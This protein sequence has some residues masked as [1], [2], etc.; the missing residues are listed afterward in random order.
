MSETHLKKEFKES[1]LSRNRN[2]IEKKFEILRNQTGI[3]K[4]DREYVEGDMEDDGKKWTIK[5]W[6]KQ[7]V[8]KYDTLKQSMK[9]PFKCPGC[10][11]HFH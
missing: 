3:L 9:L 7:T 5:G 1:D 8:T 4:Q 10:K 2:I 11:K 6:I